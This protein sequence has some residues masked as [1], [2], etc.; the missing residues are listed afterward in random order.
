MG[1][2]ARV[3]SGEEQAATLRMW[4]ASGK[5]EQRLALRA[6]VVL[7]ASEGLGLK[8]TEEITCL[9]W[10]RC[11][12]RRKCILAHGSLFVVGSHH[13][14]FQ[15]VR[16]VPSRSPVRIESKRFLTDA[17]V[18][19][20]GESGN[21]DRHAHGGHRGHPSPGPDHPGK[22]Q[23]LFSGF[24]GSDAHVS[25]YQH[26]S[27]ALTGRLLPRSRMHSSRQGIRDTGPRMGLSAMAGRN[28]PR[29]SNSP[30]FHHCNNQ[31]IEI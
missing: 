14:K 3:E 8:E 19:A 7:L 22:H 27:V 9:Q 18:L 26:F 4:A 23:L 17:D 30:G 16:K 12:K 21:H 24:L 15:L 11:L 10:Q 25:V 13:L 31:V 20:L 29:R 6:R 1:A 2:W 5:T 28:I